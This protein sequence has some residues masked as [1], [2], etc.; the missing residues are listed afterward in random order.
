MIG[1]G[2][3]SLT[4]LNDMCKYRSKM[5]NLYVGQIGGILGCQ[6][7]WDGSQVS[8]MA[9]WHVSVHYESVDC[10][11]FGMPSW[12]GWVLG[13]SQSWMT[14][15]STRGKCQAWSSSNSSTVSSREFVRG[16]TGGILQC[17]IE[18]DG[19]QV[20]R[21]A[22]WHVSGHEQ[23]VKLGQAVTLQHSLHR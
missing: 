16:Q 4:R 9:E 3:R 20:S 17:L 13:L 23:C 22:E 8:H 7:D 10:G 19:S 6:V 5:S 12:L 15:V 2:P 21:M 1:M 14:C 18:W 11:Y